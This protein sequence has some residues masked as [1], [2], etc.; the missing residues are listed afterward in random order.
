MA[1]HVILGALG[2]YI[3]GTYMLVDQDI[4]SFDNAFDGVTN[5]SDLP[6]IFSFLDAEENRLLVSMAMAI[7]GAA[8]GNVIGNYVDDVLLTTGELVPR[9]TLVCNTLFALLGISLNLASLRR[10]VY[11]RSVLLQSFAGS[12][13][14]AASA[15]AG[16]SSD[17][18]SLFKSKGLRAAAQNSAVNLLLSCA[19]FF[20]ALEVER[21]L[22][23]VAEVDLNADGVV[24]LQEVGYHY[25][26]LAPP[27]TACKPP[28]R[29]FGVLRLGGPRCG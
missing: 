9:G 1:H 23:S 4:A 3:A 2:A 17:Q 22:A 28:I 19:V 29:L 7:A 6:A 13:C 15:F 21:L 25:G 20:V 14:G 16:H 24:A 18:H 11:K 26:W 10:S 5:G 12:F 8:S 27:A